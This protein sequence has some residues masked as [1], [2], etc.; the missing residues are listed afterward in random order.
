M[1]VFDI[2]RK[3][4]NQETSEVIPGSGSGRS[5]FDHYEPNAHRKE[6]IFGTLKISIALRVHQSLCRRHHGQ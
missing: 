6:S 2:Y 4:K 5:L 3:K 1:R